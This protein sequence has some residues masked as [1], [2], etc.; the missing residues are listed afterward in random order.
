MSTEQ[1]PPRRIFRGIAAILA[2]IISTVILSVGTDMA[3]QSAG[4]YPPLSEPNRFTTQLLLVATV[5]RTVYGVAGSYLTAMLAPDHPMRHALVLG[6]FG[7]VASIV[8]AIAMW[9]V[10]QHWYPLTLVALAIPGAWLGGKLYEMRRP[11]ARA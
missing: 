1:R 5:Y 9:D 4:I 10:G 8:G 7:F 2:G 11:L 3:L 6:V